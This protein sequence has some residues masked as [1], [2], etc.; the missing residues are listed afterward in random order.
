MKKI[1]LL[2][3]ILLVSL[4]GCTM[5]EPVAEL[6]TM[7][8]REMTIKEIDG[9]Y[10]DVFKAVMTVLQDQEY[11]VENTDYNS[12]LVIAQKEVTTKN[13]GGLSEFFRLG[14]VHNRGA[15]IKAS[16]TA[17]EVTKNITRVRISLQEKYIA[18][19]AY[20]TTDEQVKNIQEKQVY[21]TLFNQIRT[22]VERI[23]ASK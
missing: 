12:G 4:V 6:S 14:F 9:E 1:I 15:F 2:V 8:I 7:Q 19:A 22:E 17:N 20:G 5:T 21:D 3:V 23:K 13:G 10:K 11:I 18:R 16:I